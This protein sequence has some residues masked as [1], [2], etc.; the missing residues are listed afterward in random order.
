[1]KL[2]L[3]VFW[4]ELLS[5]DSR[6]VIFAWKT[7]SKEEQHAVWEHLHRMAT[8]EGWLEPQRVSARAALSGLR[9]YGVEL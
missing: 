2:P 6:R 8:E 7:L 4:A 5:R 3:E 9:E 1:M